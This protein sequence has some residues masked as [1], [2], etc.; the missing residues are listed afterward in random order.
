L[1]AQGGPLDEAA[2]RRVAA[3]P[4]FADALALRDRDDAAKVVGL[5]VAPLEDYRALLESLAR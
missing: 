3:Q 4:G 1:V 2:A 5:A